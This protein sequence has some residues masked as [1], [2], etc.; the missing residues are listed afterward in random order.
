VTGSYDPES[1]LT[2]WGIG[3]PGPDYN[4]DERPGDNLYSDSVVALDADTGKLKWH[5]Q[6]TPHDVWD[7]DS[8]Q[9][10]VLADIQW[11]GRARKAMFWANRNGFFYVLDRTTGEFLRGA[12]FSKVTWA[13]GLDPR[14][15]PI[16]DPSKMPTRE[17]VQV[18]PGVQGATNWYSSSFSPRTGLFYIPT[19]PNYWSVYTKFPIE[20]EAGQRYTGGTPRS[21]VPG[22]RRGIINTRNEA[23]GSGAIRAIDP[24]TGQL[25]W[26]FPMTDV[27]D[28]GLMTTASD[29]VFGGGR[30]GYFYALD[31]RTGKQLWRASLG[32]QVTSAP[33]T[34]RV[35]NRQFVAVAAGSALF[36]FALPE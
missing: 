24:L 5:F 7:Y 9:I 33:I 29:L 21:E 19:W 4:D 1:N 27:T 28:A 13:T 11:Q 12:P 17:G 26:E 22:L 36:S 14:G 3:N 34:Y 25:K 16:V 6:F 32:G 15:R 10:P 8:V 35:G 30:E 18:Y 23:D 31:A 2:Y 20:Y